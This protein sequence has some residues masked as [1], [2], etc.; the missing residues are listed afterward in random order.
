M[1]SSVTFHKRLK[2]CLESARRNE[3]D[4]VFAVQ[5]S[6]HSYQYASV[7][8]PEMYANY[9]LH[10]KPCYANECL[11]RGTHTFF[12]IDAKCTLEQ[13]QWD[14]KDAFIKAFSD[15][16][17]N[18]F[19]THL[20]IRIKRKNL[21]FSDSCRTE[22]VSFHCVV[23]LE[24][25]YWKVEDRKLLKAFVARLRS[26]S[27]HHL[28]FYTYMQKNNGL[29]K[30][31]IID[32]RVYSKNRL[33]R[34]VGCAKTENDIVL[35]PYKQQLSV[36]TI[37]DHLITV[38]DTEERTAFQYKTD[39]KEPPI[40]TNLELLESLARKHGG[41][42]SSTEG[43][44]IILRNL[45]KTRVC[46]LTGVTHDSNNCYF[47][48]KDSKL[49]FHCHGCPGQSKVVHEFDS[50]KEF[51]RY[52][53]YKVLLKSFRSDPTSVTEDL[54][55]R[56]LKQS[57]V[58]I[59]E[60]GSPRYIT[61]TNVPCKGFQNRLIGK[62]LISCANLFHKASDIVLKHEDQK[63]VFSSILSELSKSRELPCFNKTCWVP[64]AKHSRYQ[65]S[66]DTNTFNSFPGYSLEEV[67][68]AYHDINFED[69]SVYQLLHRNLC[70]RDPGCYI[71][72]CKSIAHKLQRSFEKLPICH[73]WAGTR[74]GVGKSSLTIFLSRLFSVNQNQNT[75]LSYSNISS[76]CHRFNNE[77][78]T[79][80]W[81]TLEEVK[82]SGKL[83]EFDNFLKDFVSNP[84]VIQEKKGFDKEYLRNYTTCLIMSN[85]IHIVKCDQLDRRMVFY[86]C[87]DEV[88]N[89]K[90]FFDKLYTE[91][92]SIPVMKA[93]FEYF[94][95]LDIS[96]WDYRKFP[97]TKIRKKIIACSRD[98]NLRFLKYLFKTTLLSPVSH[99]TRQEL[100]M[101]WS[102]FVLEHGIQHYKR[103]LNFVCSSFE[104]IMNVDYNE[105]NNIYI[106]DRSV[107]AQTLRQLFGEEIL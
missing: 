71:Y 63:L 32:H 61:C 85:E 18:A 67:Q 104:L 69:T 82:S 39:I 68:C 42:I 46:T 27:L 40:C 95:K 24:D 41:T 60:P 58:F 106:L 36:K 45:E 22:K 84:F 52:E 92:D 64:Y 87:N 100:F 11:H 72:L 16:L 8:T 49:W 4:I 25:Y 12:D 57:V 90:I 62:G 103:D 17:V 81:V 35:K 56:Y 47:I 74:P 7:T 89:D 59:D 102:E 93:C 88:R 54:I 6:N 55:R 20:S 14:S 80:L 33:M 86:T 23:C 99:I 75:S 101:F 5:K 13:L 105:K 28:G 29:Y 43:S 44:L 66:I 15:F 10:K 83:R 26:E 65:P 30:E 78:T 79:N 34:T 37:L 38:T 2:S 19:E 70:N 1:Q 98:V 9:I 94:M 91:F 77:L 31:S 73:V 48:R 76:F 50:T 3:D 51:N 53:S 21:R 96:N 97:I 107:V